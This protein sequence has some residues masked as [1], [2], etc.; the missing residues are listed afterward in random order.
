MVNNEWRWRKWKSR[1][2]LQ[3]KSSPD[4]AHEND[5]LQ[6]WKWNRNV[7]VRSVYGEER[8]AMGRDGE[9]DRIEER[10]QEGAAALQRREEGERQSGRGWA[11][12][13]LHIPLLPRVQWTA[14]G[15]VLVLLIQV[16]SSENVSL[17]SGGNFRGCS[18]DTQ[19]DLWF[20][21]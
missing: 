1:S 14:T 17:S 8:S 13:G 3:W 7:N 6:Q 16:Q 21:K 11:S 9:R 2:N 20:G 19:T 12:A 18:V 5:S 4:G 10:N 15:V